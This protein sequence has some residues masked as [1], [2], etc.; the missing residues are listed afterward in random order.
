[1][2]N[3]KGTELSYAIKGV[4]QVISDENCAELISLIPKEMK[5]ETEL[6]LLPKIEEKII[7]TSKITYL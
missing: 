7:H 6:D 3:D 2:K 5:R 4:V 1:M